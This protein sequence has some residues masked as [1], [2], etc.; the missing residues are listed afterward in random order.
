MNDGHKNKYEVIIIGSGIAGLTSALLFANKGKKVA[1]FEQSPVIA[2]LF[3]GFNRRGV[4]FETGFHYSGVLGPDEVG[5]QMFKM[6]G[7]DVP[8]EMCNPDGYD[9]GYLVKSKRVFKIPTGYER[10]EKKLIEFFP[11]EAEGIKKYLR[12][13]REE[14]DAI[15]FLNFHKKQY[16]RE[17]LFKFIGSGKTFD[18]V[19]NECFTDAELKTLLSFTSVLYGVPPKEAS[20]MFHCCCGGIMYESAWKLKDGGDGLIDIFVK[21][22]KEK[23]VDIFTGKKAVNIEETGGIK[24]VFFEDGSHYLCDMC[25]AAVHPKE[26]IKIAPQD[27]YRQKNIDR[28]KAMEETRGFFILFGV[29]EGDFF[30]QEINNAGFLDTD[31][32]AGGFKDFMYVNVHSGR[33]LPGYAAD[34]KSVENSKVICVVLSVDSDDNIWNAPENEYKVKKAE[35]EQKIKTRL[36]AQWPGISEKIKFME[37]ATPRTFKHYVNYYGSYGIKRKHNEAGVM[38]IT[39]TPGLFLIGQSTVAPGLIGAMISAFLLDKLIERQ[40][41]KR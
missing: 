4:H 11:H 33:I 6:L 3:S 12:M 26:F 40:Q 34:K 19:L 18:E 32:L 1:V 35:M 13:V 39:K 31:G 36:D 29:M 28:I 27:V 20:F 17:E 14:I 37:T 22:L 30:G 2:P 5:G 41:T 7:L 16:S 25:A 21:A 8:V 23:G 24:K 10:L 15:P 9:N 38:P